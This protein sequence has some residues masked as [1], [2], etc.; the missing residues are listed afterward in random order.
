MDTMDVVVLVAIVLLA[1]AAFAAVMAMQRKR[2]RENLQ[3]RFGPEYERAVDEQGSRRKAESQLASVANKRDK[4]EIRE[5]TNEE[6]ERYNR[7]WSDV[8]AAF[9]DSPAAATRDAD[10]LVGAV[11]RDRGYPVDDFDTQAHMIA[12]DH[13]GVVEHYRAA[14]RIG[15]RSDEASTEELRQAFVH[16]RELFGQLLSPSSSSDSDGLNGSREDSIDLRSDE[17]THQSRS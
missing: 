7:D 5:L 13:P 11:M 4:L 8:Q 15:S 12:A 6:R 1:L 3:E 16:Y 17:R 2:R 10:R 9:V 14:H